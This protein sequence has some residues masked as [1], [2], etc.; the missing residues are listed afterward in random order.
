MFIKKNQEFIALTNYQLQQKFIA[1]VVRLTKVLT[2][3][4]L[5]N[6]A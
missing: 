5:N 4:K 3:T 6:L 2:L 1:K